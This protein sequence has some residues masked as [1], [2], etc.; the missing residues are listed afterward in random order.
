MPVYILLYCHM[1]VI[2]FFCIGTSQSSQCLITLIKMCMHTHIVVHLKS[3][4][5]KLA[6]IYSKRASTSLISLELLYLYYYARFMSSFAPARTRFHI[7]ARTRFHFSPRTRFHI[8]AC[9]RLHISARTL[10]LI[11]HSCHSERSAM[12]SSPLEQAI[13]RR[14]ISSKHFGIGE[15]TTMDRDVIQAHNVKIKT[16][17]SSSF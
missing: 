13:Q 1:A 9:T 4:G 8:S 12:S 2:F 11:A 6:S 10:H 15:E 5:T 16:A 17:Y 3:P 7:S 14:F